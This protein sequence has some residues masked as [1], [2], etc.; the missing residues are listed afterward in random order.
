MAKGKTR[1]KAYRPKPVR[2]MPCVLDAVMGEMSDAEVDQIYEKAAH[3]L[4]MLQLGSKDIESACNVDAAIRATFALAEAFEHKADIQMLCVL[5]TGAVLIMAAWNA[6]QDHEDRDKI[7]HDA[8][9]ISYMTAA[10]EPIQAVLDL[11]REM[12]KA[13]KR[14]ELLRAVDASHR[15]RIDVPLKHV[16]IT[17]EGG[18]PLR[19]DDPHYRER[20]IAWIHG[21]CRAGFLD[22][23]GRLIWRMPVTKSQAHLDKPTII[24]S[25]PS[26][27]KYTV[28]EL[29][30]G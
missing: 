12:L 16:I 3:G 26:G 4:D 17:E 13:A 22:W 24:V 28:K 6:V 27:I 10:S 2:V 8:D 18:V 30:S 23:D 14:S 5:A 11:W 1:R 19:K 20:G 15:F 25:V 29:T 9:P 21:E 7:C